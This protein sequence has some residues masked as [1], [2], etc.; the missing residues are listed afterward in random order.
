MDGNNM[1]TDWTPRERQLRAALEE[2]LFECDGKAD[3]ED[4]DSGFA[5]R[6]NLAMRIEMIIDTAL[7]TPPP[8]DPRDEM[9]RLAAE[10]LTDLLPAVN[11]GYMSTAEIAGF[12]AL[13]AIAA[14]K[15][16]TNVT[17]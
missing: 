14:V 11:E 5:D 2:V 1:T 3:V 7:S 8:P 13:A 15:G 6:P 4:S 9:L 12:A 16:G 17:T 10:A